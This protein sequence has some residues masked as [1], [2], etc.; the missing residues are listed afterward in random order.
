MRIVADDT[1]CCLIA[2]NIQDSN[3]LN[4]LNI[5]LNEPDLSYPSKIENG[6]IVEFLIKTI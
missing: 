3:L 6:I 5:A 4:Q 1:Y 2:E